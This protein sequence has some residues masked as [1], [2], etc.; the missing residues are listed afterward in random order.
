MLFISV[1][2]AI[3][4]I[5]TL[6]ELVIRWSQPRNLPPG[7]R[8]FPFRSIRSL[9]GGTVAP[10]IG[11]T[12]MA[13]KYGGVFSIRRGR[14]IIIVVSNVSAANEALRK[15]GSEFAGRPY[16]CVLELISKERN[17]VNCSDRNID[18]RNKN[19]LL[20]R[21]TKMG[22]H[23]M[24]EINSCFPLE[25]KVRKEV[26]SLVQRFQEATREPFD[27]S[28]KI[29]LAVVNSFCS[30]LFGKNYKINDPEFYDMV[31]LN[32]RLRRIYN[33]SETLDKFPFLKYFPID[34]MNDIHE[35]VS[36]RDRVFKKNLQEHRDT[37]TPHNIRDFVNALLHAS[38]VISDE[39]SRMLPQQ[40]ITDG[41]LIMTMM[42]IFYAGVDPVSG[43][44]YRALAFLIYNPHVQ[45]KLHRELDDVIGNNNIPSLI[46]R[47]RLPY[48]EA[49]IMETLRIASP[50][51]LGVT[52]R[53]LVNSEIN[54][55]AVPKDSSIIFNWWTM[56]HDEHQ[57]KNPNEFRPERFFTTNGELIPSSSVSF[58]P[59]GSCTHGCLG[60]QLAMAQL[61]LFLSRLIHEFTFSTPTGNGQNG[62][63]ETSSVI[64]TPRPFRM[65]VTKR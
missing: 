13:K 6:W 42:D 23:Y 17:G 8:W 27:P 53:A 22:L 56:H 52:H 36:F 41:D 7:E 30:V 10:H 62:L 64:Q 9:S 58:L 11:L 63:Q 49:V 55:F 32:N 60:Q 35:V 18:H 25:E 26:D 1:L 29:H 50:K 20:H 3:T 2:F 5:C 51:P 38:T 31:D 59:F 24:S 61:F 4:I 43:T 46:D 47:S 16:S 54:G 28:Y 44:L 21:I 15:K 45:A 33:N 12:N 57:W 34:L 14:E 48:L 40:I 65:L 37:F 39:N 19:D